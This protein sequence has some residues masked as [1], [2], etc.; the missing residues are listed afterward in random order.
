[1]AGAGVNELVARLARPGPPDA[2]RLAAL[3]G[4]ALTQADENPD[5]TFYTFAL[6]NGPLAGGV[7]RV[8]TDGEAALLSLTP[9]DPPGLTEAE[10]DSAAWGPRQDA[11]PNPRVA[12]EG[13]DTLTY[14][15]G[16]VTVSALWT[17]TSRRLL[18]LSLAWPAP[19]APAE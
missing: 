16:G 6:P 7:L 12:P 19:P 13:A 11:W 10:L 9:R 17:H 18:N 8:S 1:M 14:Q 3:L 15:V 4:V 5:W 2:E